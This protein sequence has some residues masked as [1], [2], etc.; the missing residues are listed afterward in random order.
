[1]YNYAQRFKLYSDRVGSF[2]NWTIESATSL[3]YRRMSWRQLHGYSGTNQRGAVASAFFLSFRFVD[4][5][6]FQCK[7]EKLGS[8]SNT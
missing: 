3:Y 4:I 1:M 7:L 8:L 5:M 2:D 6:S